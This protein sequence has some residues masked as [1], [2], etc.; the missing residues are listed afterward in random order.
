MR[1]H[2][3]SQLAALLLVGF[4]LIT[5]PSP[6]AAAKAKGAAISKEGQA[7]IGCHEPQSPSFVKEWRLSRHAKKG[8]DCYACHKAEKGEAD[9]MEHNG[10]TIAVLVTPKDCGRCHPKEEKEMTGSHHA[11]AADILNSA[12]NYLGEVVGGPEVVAV[13]CRQCHGSNVKVLANGKLDTDSWP[14]TGIGR[15]NPDGSKGSCSACH[16][17]HNFSKAQVREPQI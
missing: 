17:R 12:D 8:V 11:K 7:C 2:C 4:A 5:Y 3:F 6:G 15:V 10:F 14:N 13:G 16:A 9:A 1:R